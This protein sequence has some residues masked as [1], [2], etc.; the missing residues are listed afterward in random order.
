MKLSEK[1]QVFARK[2]GFLLGWIYLHDNWGVTLGEVW[3][4]QE[5]QKIYYREGKT[6][7][8]SSKHT[9]RLAIDLNLFISGKYIIEPEKYRPLG[10]FWELLGGIWGGRFGVKPNDYDIK[11]GFD[12]NHFEY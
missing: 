4:P 7:T 6:K 3:R 5:M 10:E 12:A 2:V 9:Q 1:Q 11:M 8:L